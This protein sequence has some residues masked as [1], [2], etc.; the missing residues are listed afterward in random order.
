MCIGEICFL[1]SEVI[2]SAVHKPGSTEVSRVRLDIPHITVFNQCATEVSTIEAHLMQIQARESASGEV[3]L[4]AA[5]AITPQGML[6]VHDN[7]FILCQY[8]QFGIGMFLN[9]FHR[10]HHT[11]IIAA[12][13]HVHHF[14]SGLQ[15]SSE[16][17][18][19]Q[20]AAFK[21]IPQFRI[22]EFIG[23]LIVMTVQSVDD[24]LVQILLYLFSIGN[25]RRDHHVHLYG[26]H[27]RLGLGFV[28]HNDLRSR[29]LFLLFQHL[30]L[31]L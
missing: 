26:L 19:I 11:N 10:Q 1:R 27:D 18:L 6:C 3:C 2:H 25:Q 28:L 7:H 5:H 31:R 8:T 29:F 30:I 20:A 9:G 13:I 21:A 15:H 12:Y 17:I 16:Y 14:R 4:Q 23:S 24:T 22:G